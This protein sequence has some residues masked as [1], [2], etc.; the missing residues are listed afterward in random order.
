MYLVM[1]C[2]LAM[3]FLPP[4]LA[5]FVYLL[6]RFAFNFFPTWN[7]SMNIS[8]WAK[9][10]SES[11]LCQNVTWPWKLFNFFESQFVCSLK[12]GMKFPFGSVVI[13]NTTWWRWPRAGDVVNT[14]YTCLSFIPNCYCKLHRFVVSSCL[15]FNQYVSHCLV[16]TFFFMLCNC[17]NHY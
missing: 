6:L 9:V 10:K 13:I 2:L 17:R 16:F 5:Q 1:K 14:Q 8:L 7:Y 4:N 15:Y 11:W 3:L 12:Q